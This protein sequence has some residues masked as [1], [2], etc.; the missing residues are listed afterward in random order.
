MGMSRLSQRLVVKKLVRLEEGKDLLSILCSL[1]RSWDFPVT[2][3]AG[4]YFLLYDAWQSR[5]VAVLSSAADSAFFHQA[6]KDLIAK[7]GDFPVLSLRTGIRVLKMFP[8]RGWRIAIAVDDH[9]FQRVQYD[10][11]EGVHAG[12]IRRAY[13]QQQGRLP[14]ELEEIILAEGLKVEHVV[15]DNSDQ[16]RDQ[17]S[18]LPRKTLFFSEATHRNRFTDKRRE[19]LLK[20]PGFSG[21]TT[22]FED[23]LLYFRPLGTAER[24]CLIGSDGRAYCSGAMM[25]FLFDLDS[26]D[27]EAVLMFIPGDCKDDVDLAVEA[28]ICLQI[29]GREIL[30]VWQKGVSDTRAAILGA[31]NHNTIS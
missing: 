19:W 28:F 21:A 11:P 10:A 24:L 22:F 1:A 25:E 31:Q 4:H 9:Q 8:G 27:F 26:R 16:H 7:V 2:I 18:V 3:I 23:G 6:E 5:L 29:G 20:Q 15:V 12:E 14:G 30:A 17:N 13:Y